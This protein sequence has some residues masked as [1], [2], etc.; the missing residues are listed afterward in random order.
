MGHVLSAPGRAE[1]V[2]EGQSTKKYLFNHLCV[3][4]LELGVVGHEGALRFTPHTAIL[5]QLARQI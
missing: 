5:L 4:S 3:P 2:V 1:K